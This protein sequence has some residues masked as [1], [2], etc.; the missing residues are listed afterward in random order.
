MGRLGKLG[1]HAKNGERE[2][3]AVRLKSYVVFFH[4]S[5]YDLYCSLDC[6]ARRLEK[7]PSGQWDN[8]NYTFF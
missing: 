1:R 7:L 6:L 2:R 5:S 4:L 8:F 3:R